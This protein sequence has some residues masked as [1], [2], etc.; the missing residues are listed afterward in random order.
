[1]FLSKKKLPIYFMHESVKNIP[2]DKKVIIILSPLHYWTK[3]ISLPVKNEKEAKK[4]AP[5]VFDTILPEGEYKY[6]V[7]KCSDD[8]FLITAYD[9]NSIKKFLKQN[10]IKL[11]NISDIYTIDQ[12][13]NKNGSYDINSHNDILLI[14]DEISSIIPKN[15][16]KEAQAL[17]VNDF[18]LPQK[19]LS[20]SFYQEDSLS[21]K[22]YTNIT[23]AL[24]ILSL[25]Y[26]IDFFY[27]LYHLNKLTKKIDTLNTLYKL[28]PTTFQ[29][30]SI[31]QKIKKRDDRQSRLRDVANYLSRTKATKDDFLN[32]FTISNGYVNILY[33]TKDK[34]KAD[35]IYKDVAKY[36]KDVSSSYDGSTLSI[37]AKL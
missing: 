2:K 14:S 15:F 22:I 7:Q 29:L 16:I 26:S 23:I 5:S 10:G 28:P 32:S 37:K 36:L 20:I 3:K 21:K 35:N 30:N 17:P 27:T 34:N 8:N 18:I 13:F 12:V 19:G 25:F 4:I 24:V 31:M 33:N 6:I 11:S 9:Q 1:M